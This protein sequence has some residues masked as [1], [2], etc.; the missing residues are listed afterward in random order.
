M[1]SAKRR[2][3]FLLGAAGITL[4]L[5]V[6]TRFIPSWGVWFNSGGN[7]AY[8]QSQAF[9]RGEL[10]LYKEPYFPQMDLV[11]RDG[12][13]QAWGLG[14]PLLR[15]PF[16]ALA[17][18]IQSSGFPDRVL[19]LIIFSL[20]SLLLLQWAR[21]SKEASTEVRLTKTLVALG[22]LFS[23]PF[24]SLVRTRFHIYEE[25]AAYGYLFVVALIIHL[26][27]TLDDPK[28]KNLFVV[29]LLAG[30]T[31]LM[32]PTT[33]IYGLIALFI[34][35]FKI[36][37]R[38]IR[39]SVELWG[40]WLFCV[41]LGA[42]FQWAQFG[43]LHPFA[44]HALNLSNDSLNIF[45]LKFDYPMRH[46]SIWA[47][48]KELFGS[49]FFNR[50]L[51]G[52]DYYKDF[53]FPG[54]APVLKFREFYFPFFHWTQ[55]A[56]CGIGFLLGGGSVF[57]K[58]LPEN[59]ETVVRPWT[60]LSLSSLFGL[61][62]FY[63]NTPALASR[64][65]IDFLPA[66]QIGMGLLML[67]L[68]HFVRD[69][70]IS[71][72]TRIVILGVM[73]A[74]FLGP[75]LINGS[76]SAIPPS[77]LFAPLDRLDFD[78]QLPMEGLGQLEPVLDRY[79]LKSPNLNVQSK[80]NGVGWNW[81]GDGSVSAA[82]QIFLNRPEIISLSISPVLP[83]DNFQGNLKKIIKVKSGGQDYVCTGIRHGANESVLI[84]EAAAVVSP[85]ASVI[86]IGFT[87]VEN[88]RKVPPF[89]LNSISALRK[90][91]SIL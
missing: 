78:N 38:S 76:R 82:V 87:E 2:T 91:P 53:I 45:S 60:I 67:I 47:G 30:A 29:S 86:F 7:P 34:L 11:W 18:L 63:S 73:G 77:H 71:K 62:I 9:L 55:A 42:V 61:T 46:Q 12:V 13:H 79:E 41:G 24:L 66:L 1:T 8:L 17:W 90:T 49:M 75:G 10:F 74:A 20:V 65:L 72:K 52:N 88:L 3:W 5:N 51:N 70:W 39:T 26:L 43:T 85:G 23:G 50:T 81:Q 31:F 32:R 4:G 35:T 28:P 59:I 22:F 48:A 21:D 64:Y 58:S 37:P 83:Y 68:F 15:L 54:V 57:K 33:G 40:G 14:L 69:L 84:F 25:T 16:D 36:R 80:I 56:L 6:L 89:R 44:P 19:F 27:K